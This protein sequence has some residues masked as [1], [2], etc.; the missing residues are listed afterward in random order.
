MSIQAA[1]EFSTHRDRKILKLCCF[2]QT[3]VL[4]EPDKNIIRK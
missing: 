2:F 3:K 1:F 4:G